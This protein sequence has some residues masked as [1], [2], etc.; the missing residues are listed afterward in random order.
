[1]RQDYWCKSLDIRNTQ[2]VGDEPKPVKCD[3]FVDILVGHKNGLL[4]SKSR[5]QLFPYLLLNIVV[6]VL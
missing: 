1:M 6:I 2:S 3:I 5:V 4:G